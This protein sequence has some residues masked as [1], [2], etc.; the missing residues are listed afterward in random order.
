MLDDAVELAPGLSLGN[1]R[2]L[3]LLCGLNVLEGRDLALRVAEAVRREADRVGLSAVFKASW[4]KANRSHPSSYRGPG[5]EQGLGWLE[6]VKRETGLPVLTDVHAPEHCAAV[7][8][9]ADVLQ[10]PAFLVRQ[11]DLIAAAAATG[12]PL[13]LKKM[14][15]MAP[16]DMANVVE[17][18]ADFGADRVVICER[19]ASFGYGRL[20]VDF[21][22]F[23]AM[24][25]LAPLSYDVTHSLQLPGALGTATGGRRELVRG[26]ALAGVSQGLAALFLEVHPEPDQAR[27]DGPCALPLDKLG[28]LLEQVAVM[29]R[30][31]KSWA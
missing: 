21:A 28:P 5:L 13:H 18:C 23:P 19:G 27:C 6:A 16:T 2:P 24:K 15:M 12:R 9:V 1:S 25:R 26:M 29:D 22:G 11:T 4:D 8:E 17:K 31:V 30:L 10:I 3:V 7:A 20:V 14:Q